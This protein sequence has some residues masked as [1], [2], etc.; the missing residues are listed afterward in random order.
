MERKQA[1]L[2]KNIELLEENRRLLKT[3]KRG[4][5]VAYLIKDMSRTMRTSLELVKKEVS[6]FGEMTDLFETSM[7]LTDS[8]K[9]MAEIL[10]DEYRYGCEEEYSSAD[11]FDEYDEEE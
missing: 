6:V 8:M 7:S 3:V 5:D 1:M 9:D 2:E 4:A 11:V 10:I